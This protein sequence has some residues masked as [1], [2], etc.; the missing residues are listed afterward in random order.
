MAAA[1]GAGASDIGAK[2][3]TGGLLR[4]G[5]MGTAGI[6]SKN[7]FAV[8]RSDLCTFAVRFACLCR[9]YLQPHAAKLYKNC[10]ASVNVP[11][12]S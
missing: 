1:S 12:H 8:L 11:I 9:E 2:A 6:A 7:F 10:I 4:I 5:L 3:P